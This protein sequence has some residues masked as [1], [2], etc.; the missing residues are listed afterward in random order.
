M[1]A[2]QFIALKSLEIG[3][4]PDFFIEVGAWLFMALGAVL[5]TMGVFFVLSFSRK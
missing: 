2:Y 1:G 4:T 3:C 5:S